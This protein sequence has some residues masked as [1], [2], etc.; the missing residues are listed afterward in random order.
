MLPHIHHAG[1]RVPAAGAVVPVAANFTSFWKRARHAPGG[2]KFQLARSGPIGGY[3][4]ARI[5]NP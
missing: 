3:G 2:V 1:D 4:H 5:A